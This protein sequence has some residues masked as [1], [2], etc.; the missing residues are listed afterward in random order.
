MAGGLQREDIV[1]RALLKLGDGN[2]T[3]ITETSDPARAAQTAFKSVAQA[4]LRSHAWNFALRRTMIEREQAAPEFGFA[5]VF[6]LPANSLRVIEIN[7]RWVS[8]PAALESPLASSE[9]EFTFEGNAVLCNETAPLKLRYV[10]DLSDDTGQWDAS[11]TEAFCCRLASEL[12]V[13]RTK[14][15][16]LKDSLKK[17]Y[18]EAIF[19]ARRVNAIQLPPRGMDD[20]SWMQARLW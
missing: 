19:D 7:D 6:Q 4:E 15:L 13:K 9:P 18:R 12:C 16:R 3:A 11:F 1:N 20:G 5:S 2:I 8:N 17:D 14:N 10:F